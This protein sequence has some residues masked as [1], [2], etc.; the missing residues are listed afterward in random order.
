MFLSVTLLILT[1]FMKAA[2]E[3][4]KVIGP[5]APLIAEEGED[6]VL[7]CSLRP[8]ISA[9][10]M[11]VEW[12]KLR[13]RTLTVHLYKDHTDRTDDQA[14]DYRGRTSLFK[15]ELKNGNT[16][17][18]LS[19]V[20]PSDEGLYNCL[21]QSSSGY[22]DINIEV[23]VKAA[24][25]FKVVGPAAPLIVKS[26][27]DVVLPCSLK[28][29]LSAVE[30]SVEW[31]KLGERTLMVHRYKDRADRTDEQAED[32]RGRTSLFK[33]DLK[34][35]NTSLKLS[36]VQPSDEGVYNCLIESSVGYSDVNI[37]L[38]V[39]EQVFHALKIAL[40]CILLFSFG[41]IVFAA[42]IWKGSPLHPQRRLSPVQCSAIASMRLHSENVRKEWDLNKYYTSE[43]GY[44]RLIPAITNC[45]KA[46]LDGCIFT[47]KSVITLKE[48]LE[49]EKSSLKELDLSYNNLK[50]SRI[51]ELSDGLKRLE[52]LRLMSCELNEES[53]DTVQSVLQSENSCLKNLDLSNN[54]LQ[55]SGVEKLCEGLKSSHC[56]LETLRL[57]GCNL[58]EQ[59]IITLSETLQA[60]ITSL[61]ELDL[62]Y[63]D[64]QGSL[65]EK[66]SE[67][68]K[69]LKTLRLMKCKLSDESFDTVQLV[70]QSENSCLKKLDLSNNDLQES[71]VKKLCAGLKSKHCTLETLRLATC[72]LSEKT[73]EYLG[74]VLQ[75]SS[76]LQKELDLSNNDLQDSGVEKLC[77]GLKSSHCKLETLRLSGCM[78]TQKACTSLAS[79]LS[80]NSSHLKELDLSYNHPGDTGEKLLSDKKEDPHC[81]L[82]TLRM[83]HAGENRIKPG[84]KK[85]ECTPSNGMMYIADCFYHEKKFCL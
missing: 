63:N 82:D 5:A 12:S 70:L 30:M 46:R 13:E 56:K 15:E 33:E 22:D 78:V 31:V 23:K 50:S 62:S 41:L 42:F 43:A 53:F 6:V 67:G 4:F 27:E 55:D 29:K 45:T 26:G 1:G 14:E 16:S 25:G 38:K 71:G 57:A 39:K 81:R 7:P 58:T 24:E 64:L 49:A 76:S 52:T 68:V 85:Y 51:K 47:E 80:S 69:R 75:Q 36:A 20:Q 32:Y 54:D 66:L 17:L 79:A 60:E 73:C 2:S 84:M 40:T 34:T 77:E 21:I 74:S 28:P 11:R 19:A 3:P 10:D 9:V 44:R 18:K 48:P 37:D 72:N 83:D 8:N 35:G 61:K 59:S 65:L